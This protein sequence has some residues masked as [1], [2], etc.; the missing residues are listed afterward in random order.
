MPKYAYVRDHA[1]GTGTR[2][3]STA[4]TSAQ[5]GDWDTTLSST[6]DYYASVS[7]AITNNTLVA[8]DFIICS[9]IH[10]HTYGANTAYDPPTGVTVISVDDT[11]IDSEKAGANEQASGGTY[12]LDISPGSTAGIVRY[13][14]MTFQAQDDLIWGTA[15]EETP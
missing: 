11:A 8:G 12:D 7:S 3:T 5:T 9:D 15:A 6:G 4:Y 1:D 10:S 13:R 2:A 14:G